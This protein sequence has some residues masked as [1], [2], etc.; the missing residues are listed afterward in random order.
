MRHR[1]HAFVSRGANEGTILYPHQHRDDTYVV[2]RT[3]FERD[4][5]RVRNPADLLGWL[6]QRYSLPMSNKDEG[7]RSPSLIEAGAIYRPVIL[8][9]PW[10]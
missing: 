6:E 7:V 10:R 2:S 3:R 4:Y 8:P 1:L 5:I 9:R